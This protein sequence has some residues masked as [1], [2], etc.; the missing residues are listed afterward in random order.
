[1]V[2]LQ[3]TAAEVRVSAFPSTH[4]MSRSAVFNKLCAVRATGLSTLQQSYLQ[5]GS[6]EHTQLTRYLDQNIPPYT[7]VG[8][9]TALTVAHMQGSNDQLQNPKPTVVQE[10]GRWGAVEGD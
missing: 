7:T 9:L 10:Y 8:G 6:H 1:M 4:C 3:V 5:A 2:P